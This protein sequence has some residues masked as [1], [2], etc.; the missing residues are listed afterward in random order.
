MTRILLLLSL[1]LFA[2]GCTTL[3]L[4]VESTV[5]EVSKATVIPK[6]ATDQAAVTESVATVKQAA[7]TKP[8]VVVK[9]AVLLGPPPVTNLWARIRSR[10][11]L[12]RENNPR[13]DKQVAWYSRHQEY[14]NRVSD[15]AQPYLYYIV[16]ML[17]KE[18]V[19]S[20]L[21]LLPIVESAF[22]PF[23]YSHGRAAGI[24]QFIP[25]TGRRL[26][27]K[28]NWWYDGRRDVYASTRAAIKLLK[29]L[30]REFNGDW[31]LALAAYNS[32][33]GTIH[34]AIRHNK[35]LGKP[36]DFFSLDLPPE[37]RA[38][39]PKLLAIKRIVADPQTHG[40]TLAPI[41]N[42][43]YFKLVNVGSQIDLSL[44]AELADIPLNDLYALNPGHNRW[45]TPPNGPH[46]LLIPKDK[47]DGF[48]ARLAKIP[49]RQLIRWVRHRIRSG[50]TLSTIAQR[51]HTSINVIKRVNGI[52]GRTIRA[53]HN[54]TIPVAKKSLRSYRLSASQ[55]RT[56]TQ[57]IPRKG[58]KV[59][60]IVSQGDTFWDLAQLHKV[61]VR[62]LAKWNNMAPRDTLVPGTKLV[63][64]SRTGKHA[65]LNSLNDI[66]IPRHRQVMKRIGYRVRNGDSLALISQKFRVTVHQ[67]LRWNKLKRE[68]VLRPGQ[69]LTLFV[70]VT[71]QSGT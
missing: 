30:A 41:A 28:Q 39:V 46:Y 34:R 50:E 27:L 19:P 35:R 9:K 43:P 3:G 38:Y 33:S 14:M 48:E 60:H 13:I 64:W 32:G 49:D 66:T 61:G 36:T 40:I 8:T 47:A 55:R 69:F 44:A 63:I 31:M 37:T 5:P 12:P 42:E 18:N 58:I 51:Y 53:G 23:A 26:G 54:I 10:F 59:T 56:H 15:R 1:M 25:S 11:S 21:A 29:S 17:E 4:Q 62:Q 65:S 7:A 71:R 20:E 45:A 2:T 6:S 70:D 67:V 57:N 22:Q 52:K 24:W 68:R 16:R